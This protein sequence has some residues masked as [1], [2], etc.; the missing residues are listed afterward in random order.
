MADPHIVLKIIEDREEQIR[1]CVGATYCLDGIYE[2]GEAL[3]IHNAATGREAKM[4]HVVKKASKK[5]NI[6]VI[7][8]GPGGL[9]AARVAGE[10]GHSVKVFEAMPWAGGQLSLAVRNPRRQ[11]LQGIIDW[12]VEELKRLGVEVIYNHP[13]ELEDITSLESDVVIVATGGL[14]QLPPLETG[15]DNVITSWDVLSGESKPEGSVIFY[16]DNGTHS[17]L[18]AAELLAQSGA[19]LEIVTP[20]RTL[21]IDVGGVNHVPYARSFNENEVRVTLNQR[22]LRV[23]KGNPR[24][25]VDIGSDH[26]DHFVTREADWVVVDH[27]TSPNSDLYFELKPYSNNGG[28]VDYDA[29]LKGN[30][31][32]RNEDDSKLFDLYR[33]GDAVASR[34]IHAAIYD[35]LRLVKDI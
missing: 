25:R 34:N 22:V 2:N 20:E 17:S 4:P 18:S 8:A 30:P 24:L 27:G 19:D 13:A 21:G 6:T 33:I 10:R 31:Q 35:A 12:R 15:Q 29:L 28:E 23:E 26:S 16:D 5:R 7:G 1:P 9:E 11:D 32:P 14:P 3:C